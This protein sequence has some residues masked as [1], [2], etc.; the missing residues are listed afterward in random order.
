MI[1]SD[2]RIDPDKLEVWMTRN[3]IDPKDPENVELMQRVAEANIRQVRTFRRSDKKIIQLSPLLPS[4]HR[5]PQRTERIPKQQEKDQ[6]IR[7]NRCSNCQ[8]EPSKF[9]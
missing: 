2:G 4:H 5:G 7:Y 8:V 6:R 1:E 3:L 9:V